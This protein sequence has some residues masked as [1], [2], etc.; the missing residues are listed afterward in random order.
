VT[1][2][3]GPQPSPQ[4]T[5][6]PPVATPQPSVVFPVPPEAKPTTDSARSATRTTEAEASAEK[7]PDRHPTSSLKLTGILL[8]PKNP[9]ALINGRIV[10]VGDVVNGA[11]VL[12]IDSSS[13]VRVE[14]KA[15]E[16]KLELR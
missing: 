5:G 13:H 14:Y 8:D 4:A 1:Y 12:A 6:P 9:S 10:R 3:A 16:Y 7:E 15:K 11:K 2:A